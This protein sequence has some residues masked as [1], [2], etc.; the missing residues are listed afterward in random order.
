[1]GNVKIETANGTYTVRVPT[2]RLGSVH[3]GIM[4]ACAPTSDAKDENGNPVQ[5]PADKERFNDNFEKWCQ[6]VLPSIIVAGES[7]CKF[8]DMPGEDQYAIFIALMSRVNISN[9]L[10][11]IVE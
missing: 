4:Q 7:S 2:G 10:F 5:S 1:M 6:K 9:D 11:R 3:F 8:D